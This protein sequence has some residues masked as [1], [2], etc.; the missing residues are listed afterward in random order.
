MLKIHEIPCQLVSAPA[1]SSSLSPGWSS[2]EVAQL[3]L[4]PHLSSLLRL[5]PYVRFLPAAR[6]P[7]A[8]HGTALWRSQRAYPKV[9]S[10]GNL[11]PINKTHHYTT[12]LPPSALGVP[13]SSCMPGH[14]LLCSSTQYSSFFRL[15]FILQLGILSKQNNPPQVASIII[16]KLVT[17]QVLSSRRLLSDLFICLLI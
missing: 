11:K 4:G 8:R 10:Y 15:S 17:F 16:H 1:P 3:F 14:P 7:A 6:H 12:P 2:L 5:P 9:S 13:N